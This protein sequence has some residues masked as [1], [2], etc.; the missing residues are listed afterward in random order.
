MNIHKI[1]YDY[2]RNLMNIEDKLNIA[3]IFIFCQKL[4]SV[5]FAE[6]LYTENHELF[7]EELNY[8]YKD[9][10]IVF[11]LNLSDKQIK[12]CFEKVLEQVIKQEDANGYYKAVFEK[13][14]YALAIC[15]IVNYNFDEIEFKKF[16]KNLSE[17]L[18]FEF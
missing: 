6:L 7:I 17:Q 13:D 18:K 9:A 15:N 8:F 1:I 14:E 10:E 3:T 11:N 2:T 4:N 12:N 5:K 16:T